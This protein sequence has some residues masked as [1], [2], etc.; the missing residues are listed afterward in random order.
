MLKARVFL[1][2]VLAAMGIC[3]LADQTRPA[4]AASSS[5]AA[6]RD[7]SCGANDANDIA[8]LNFWPPLPGPAPGTYGSIDDLVAKLGTTGDG[9][10]RQLA[11]GAAIPVWVQ[12]DAIIAEAIKESFE[13]AIRTN[14][15]V[16]FYVDDHIDWDKRP[17]LWNWYD[18]AKP[19]YRP[20]N[21]KNVEWYDWEGTPNKRR[22][23]TPVGSPSQSPHMCYNSPAIEK[24]IG[25]IVSEKIGPALRKEIDALE[26]AQKEY[27]FAGVTVGAEAG[28]DD[29]SAIPTLDHVPRNPDPNN[30]LQMQIAKL[31]TEAATLMDQDKA[32]HSSLGYCS[33][34]NAGYSKANPPAD[35]NRA[36]AEVNRTFIAFWDKK[37]VDAGIPCSRV[38]TH[39]AAPQSQSGDAP[40][41]IVFNPYARP[42]WTTY[43]IGTL[44]DGFQ[45]LY[46]ALAKHGDPAWGGVEANAAFPKETATGARVGWEQ[47]LAWHFNHGAKLVGVNLGASEET[48]R[49]HLTKRAFGVEAI[50]AY[51]KFLNGEPLSEGAQTAAPGASEDMSS[52]APPPPPPALVEKMQTIQRDA[53]AW[54]RAHPE[55]RPQLGPLFQQLDSRLRANDTVQAQQ[56]A[57]AILHMIGADSAAK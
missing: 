26:Q 14:V 41:G 53:P 54:L 52:D 5:S 55:R 2:A 29:Y 28:F 57:D 1:A 36:L 35:I 40:I 50:A 20:D 24:E 10:T 42:G 37:F 39:V 8:Y 30:P 25:R 21:R 11:V 15:A 33:L 9:R 6:V 34:T 13:T 22:Y 31:A 17:D 38:Y 16:H 51:K 7:D 43:P 18:P 45:P 56:I 3:G 23:M 27:L 46:D 12:D 19:G 4:E 48:L 49:S 44:A 47:Y 32:P